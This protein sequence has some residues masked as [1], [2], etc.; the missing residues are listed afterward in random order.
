MTLFAWSRPRGRRSS[1]TTARSAARR[2]GR[3]PRA[4]TRGRRRPRRCPR[5]RRRRTARYPSPRP[6][7]RPGCARPA[8]RSAEGVRS[9]LLDPAAAGEA[10]DHPDGVALAGEPHRRGPAEVAV[11]AE[12][13]TRIPNSL[14]FSQSARVSRRCHLQQ[15]ATIAAVTVG[16]MPARACSPPPPGAPLSRAAG[17]M[18]CAFV[19]WQDDRKALRR[20]P[21]RRTLVAASETHQARPAS[22]A[23]R[24]TATSAAAPAGRRRPR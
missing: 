21:G 11:A 7:S 24:P 3:S 4:R 6:R 16:P 15:P 18:R 14:P 8:T 17:A 1:S 5:R 13:Q 9:G 23:W 22:A 10:V 20:P 19:G 12:N 2:S